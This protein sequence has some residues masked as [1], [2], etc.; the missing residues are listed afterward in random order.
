[1]TRSDQEKNNSI[2]PPRRIERTDERTLRLDWQDGAIGEIPLARLRQECPCAHCKGETILGKVYKP[3]LL[4][5]DGEGMS[6]RVAIEK[7]GSSAIRIAWK[8]GHDTGIYTW[9]YLRMLGGT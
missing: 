5:T 7:V 1:M 4:P 3:A 8:D 2:A 9:E 6:D